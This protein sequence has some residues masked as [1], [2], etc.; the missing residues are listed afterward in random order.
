MSNNKTPQISSNQE[1][2]KNK[3]PSKKI[4]QERFRNSKKIS[5]Q[6]N[7]VTIIWLLVKLDE[8]GYR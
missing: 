5:K 8:R 6:V 1:N 2:I 4:N 3:F 7:L